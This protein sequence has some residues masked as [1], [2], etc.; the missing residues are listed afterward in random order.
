MASYSSYKKIL[1]ESIVA[2][3]IPESKISSTALKNYTV[4]WIRGGLGA[5]SGGCCCLWTVPSG[6]R[7]VTFELWGAGG[8]GSGACS[9][10]RCQHW[11]GAQGGYYNSRTISVTPGW[12][13]TV[14]A[15]GV[16][17]CCQFDCVGC[18]GCASFITGCNLSNFCAA[19][20]VGGCANA[21]WSEKCNS[22]WG[23][24][25]L[26]PGGW[27]GDFGMGNHRGAFTG[28][29]ACHCYRHKFCSS[30]GPFLGSPGV[31]GGLT[32]CWI[33]CGCW[34]V[35][36]SAGGQSAMTTYCGNACGQGGTGGSGVVKITYF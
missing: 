28:S 4:Q 17:P 31:V 2:G 18:T 27:G 22:D 11:A 16:F 26:V 35:P 15:G 30:G 10:G 13:Y 12:T 7:R 9:N 24:C 33:R 29:F 25:C 8:N 14:C 3:S 19:G 36:Y 21:D 20:G 23:A 1:T 34:S 32:E 6:V 5:A